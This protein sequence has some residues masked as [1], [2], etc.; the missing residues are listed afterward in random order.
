[1]KKK[2]ISMIGLALFVGA[3]AF[4]FQMNSDNNQNRGM[5]MSNLA[6]L[7]ASAQ[8]IDPECPNGCVEGSGG[9]YCYDYYP[10][11]A[12]YDGWD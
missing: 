4:N 2:I 11:L 8:E 10:D 3:V 5:T 6:A 1:M 7:T 9:C 12:E